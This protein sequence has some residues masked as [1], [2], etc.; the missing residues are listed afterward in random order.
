MG[1]VNPVVLLPGALVERAEAIAEGLCASMLL[2]VGQFCTNPGIVLVLDDDVSAR[3]VSQLAARAAASPRGTMLHAGIR[4]AFADGVRAIKALPGVKVLADG[5]ASQGDGCGAGAC[6][7]ATDDATFLAHGELARE[8]FGPST[9]VVRC[10]STT[11]LAAVVRALPGQLTATIHASAGDA[12]T[13]GD[14]VADLSTRAGRLVWNG[15]PTGVEVCHAMHHGGPYPAT[16]DPRFTSVGT[17]SIRRFLRPV[18]YQDFPQAGLPAALRDDN[19][20]G[21]P[22]RVDGTLTRDPIPPMA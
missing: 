9:L 11:A 16:T 14:L 12:G 6:V 22:R 13:H 21:I 8:V 15:F 4:D 17:A 5:T 10:A 2:G 18:C 19:P 1:S 3:F 20:L 7:L